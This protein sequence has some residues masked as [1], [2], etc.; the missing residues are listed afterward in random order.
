MTAGSDLYGP[1]G[2]V[3]QAAQEKPDLPHAPAAGRLDESE[4]DPPPTLK[5]P[6]DRI[7]FTSRLLQLSQVTAD[8]SVEER[9]VS[10][11]FPHLLQTNS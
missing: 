1:H 2:A 11:S 9:I 3:V 8:I 4:A 7:F 6:V 10:N 5:L